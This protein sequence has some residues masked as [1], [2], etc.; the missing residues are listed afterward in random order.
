MPNR[1]STR[2]AVAPA[3]TRPDAVPRPAESALYPAVKRF[4]SDRGY[5]AKGEVCGCD[6]AA[7]R[8][9]EPPVLAVV[10]LKLAASMELVLQAVDRM[11]AAD[12]VWLAVPATRRGRDRDKRLHRLCRLLGVGL[13]AVR[14]PGGAVEVLAEPA[15]YRPRPN[16][17]RRGRIL[18]EH[19]RRVGDPA[20]GG[21]RGIPVETAYRQAALGCAVRMLDGPQRPRD[22]VALSPVVGRLLARNVYGWFERVARGRYGLTEAGRAALAARD[23]VGSIRQES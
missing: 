11:A 16:L 17:R 5:E 2:R 4:L 9:G 20:P 18:S 8:L 23:A 12:E 19:A 10:E 3:T 14:L 22:L 13:L 1:I 15:P 6:V 7:V 21:T